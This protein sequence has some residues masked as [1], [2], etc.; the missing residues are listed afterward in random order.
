MIE[1]NPNNIIKTTE[2]QQPFDTFYFANRIAT[3]TPNY[4]CYENFAELEAKE[5]IGIET[6][7]QII[8]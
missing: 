5:F 2:P 6:N 7:F 3:P 1:V 4:P 8:D